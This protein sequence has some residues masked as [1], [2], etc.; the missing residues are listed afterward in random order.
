[1]LPTTAV[2]TTTVQPDHWTQQA[3]FQGQFTGNAHSLLLH[4][5]TTPG[6]LLTIPGVHCKGKR[7]LVD[8]SGVLKVGVG[9]GGGGGSNCIPTQVQDIPLGGIPCTP[10]CTYNLMIFIAKVYMYTDQ[11]YS[12]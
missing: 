5:D 3:R 8:T 7:D 4:A 10:T 9:G 11:C 6:T 1:M 12:M 2:L